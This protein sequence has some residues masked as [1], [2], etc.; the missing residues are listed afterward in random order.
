MPI[1]K[2]SL[3]YQHQKEYVKAYNKTHYSNF[4]IHLSK[5]KDGDLIDLLSSMKGKRNAFVK[6][7]IRKEAAK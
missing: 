7:A 5:A 2:N 3:A 4:I 6:Q 1:N